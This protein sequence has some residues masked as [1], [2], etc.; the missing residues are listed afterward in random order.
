MQRPRSV[1]PFPS[2]LKVLTVATF[3]VFFSPLMTSWYAA[4]DLRF[5]NLILLQDLT[6]VESGRETMFNEPFDLSTVIVEATN[7][8]KHEAE[9]KGLDFEVDL[10]GELHMVVGDSSKVKTVVA[11]LTANAR[12]EPFF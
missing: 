10:A 11:N 5:T 4:F 3:R 7:L 9:R 2:L 8:Y 1:S 6:K 12:K